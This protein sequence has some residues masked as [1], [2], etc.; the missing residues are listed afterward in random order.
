[1]CH[2]TAN[3]SKKQQK[4]NKTQ[5]KPQKSQSTNEKNVETQQQ[6]NV[7]ICYSTYSNLCLCVKMIWPELKI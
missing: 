7:A 6:V 2:G 5:K 1:M 4:T 3:N